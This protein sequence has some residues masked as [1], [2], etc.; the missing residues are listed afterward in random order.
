MPFRR[1]EVSMFEFLFLMACA[2]AIVAPLAWVR[3]KI[4]GYIW[5]IDD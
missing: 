1:L 3:E 2:I 5:R 4:I